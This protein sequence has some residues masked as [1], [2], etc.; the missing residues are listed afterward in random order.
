M[1]TA[2]TVT[3]ATEYVKAALLFAAKKDIRYWLNGLHIELSHAGAWLVATDGHTVFVHRIAGAD[4]E[5]ATCSAI[6]ESAAF[7]AVAKSKAKIVDVTID[8]DQY[9]LAY[10]GVSAAGKQIDGIYPDWR[11]VVPRGKQSGEH[12]YFHPDYIARVD[13]AGQ[14][15]GKNKHGC[16]I[17]PNGPVD[18]GVCRYNDVAFCGVMPIRAGDDRH[19]SVADILA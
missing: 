18:L 9:K 10:A 16:H 13:K 3:I 11:R 4:A 2:T 8:G 15:I 17:V 14:A 5:R 19:V 7:D 6:I 12:G 1:T